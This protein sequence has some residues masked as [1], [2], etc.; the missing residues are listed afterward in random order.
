LT[1][2]IILFVTAKL[3]DKSAN[4]LSVNPLQGIDPIQ[5]HH[6]LGDLFPFGHKNLFKPLVI[7]RNKFF[8]DDRGT[9]VLR[10]YRATVKSGNRL[11]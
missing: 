10:F 5:T 6:P 4:Q 11:L 7:L 3:K 2:R 8:S 1:N 9:R